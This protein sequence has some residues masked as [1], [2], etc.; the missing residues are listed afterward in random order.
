MARAS[1][2]AAQ[3]LSLA[4]T[5]LA[6]PAAAQSTIK[7]PGARAPYVLELEPHFLVGPIDPPGFHSGQG[8]GAG[9]RG[10]L[11]ILPEGFIAPLND[12][13]GIGIG[14]DYLHY[15]GDD[16]GARRTCE[17]YEPAPGGVPVCVETSGGDSDYLYLPVVMQW[18]F[19]LHRRWSVFGEPGIAPYLVDFDELRFQPFVFYAGGRFHFS[20]AVTLTM[21]LGYPTFS[22]GVS[23]L[24]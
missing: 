5:L 14:A 17:R 12:S 19:Y 1:W 15:A 7:T 13:V 3:M 23:F 8:F 18:N 24:L 4:F 9:F 2:A 20:D 22:L 6:L 10:S 21:R 16:E 11:L